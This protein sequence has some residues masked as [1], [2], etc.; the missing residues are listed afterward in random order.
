[1]LEVVAEI[2]E[3]ITFTKKDAFAKHLNR[4]IEFINESEHGTA[5]N[6]SS[7][8]FKM[9]DF[10]KG[11]SP[12]ISE[13]GKNRKYESGVEALSLIFDELGVDVDK[14]ECFVLFHIRSLGKFKIKET[15]L[16][17]EL[18]GLYGEY[19]EYK[20]EEKELSYAL[21]SLMKKKFINYRKG[22]I[23]VNPNALFR[24]KKY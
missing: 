11:F 9:E 8:V 2:K 4:C 14:K 21:R 12:F 17:D 15:K 22:N 13:H 5:G 7:V 1:M 24:Y 3:K 18:K 19:K 10:F 23:Q 16:Y 20:L 6:F